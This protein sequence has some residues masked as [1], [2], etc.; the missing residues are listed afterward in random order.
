MDHHCKMSAVLGG[1]VNCA[2]RFAICCPCNVGCIHSIQVNSLLFLLWLLLPV[3]AVRFI[4]V[5]GIVVCV[6]GA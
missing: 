2:L 5:V 4:V 6:L 1:G 3:I